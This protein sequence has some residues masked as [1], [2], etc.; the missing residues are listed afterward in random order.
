MISNVA[1]KKEY[2]ILIK[3]VAK[4]TIKIPVIGVSSLN[5]ENMP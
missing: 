2:R 1:A 4:K 3:K 5:R